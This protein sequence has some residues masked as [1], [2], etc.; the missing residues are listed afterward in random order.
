[1]DQERLREALARFDERIERRPDP[2]P[3]PAPEELPEAETVTTT[4]DVRI[5]LKRHAQGNRS[6]T[7]WHAISPATGRELDKPST[8]AALGNML[9]YLAQFVCDESS[10]G[11][12]A[13]WIFKP[14]RR[15]VAG[16]AENKIPQGRAA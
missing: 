5:Q 16:S 3:P 12:W 7:S 2:P 10:N 6:W 4:V 15:L 8:R 1:M 13:D 11:G 14:A 9:V